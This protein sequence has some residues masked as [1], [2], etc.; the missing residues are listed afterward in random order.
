MNIHDYC[1]SGNLLEVKRLL[2]TGIDVNLKDQNGITA[3][4]CASSY[5]YIDIAEELLIYGA[6]INEKVVQVNGFASIGSA[7][8]HLAVNNK[9]EMV[10]FFN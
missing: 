4:Q 8:L 2:F 10:D 7:A 3:L 5:G 1:R 9:P 6:S